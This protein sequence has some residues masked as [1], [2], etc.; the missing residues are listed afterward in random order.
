M[1]LAI[2]STKTPRELTHK[3]LF[4]RQLDEI[5]LAGASA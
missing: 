4:Q 3:E 1:R 2:W 5:E